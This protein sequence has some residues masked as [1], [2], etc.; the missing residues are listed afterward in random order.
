MRLRGRLRKKQRKRRAKKENWILVQFPCIVCKRLRYDLVPYH[1]PTR[2]PTKVWICENC[3]T[4]GVMLSN[5]EEPSEPQ[6]EESRDKENELNAY[7]SSS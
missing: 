1:N 4:N 3:L 6:E 7:K 2:N 5:G